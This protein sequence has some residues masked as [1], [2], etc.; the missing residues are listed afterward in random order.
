MITKCGSMR[1]VDIQE[2]CILG[3]DAMQSGEIYPNS[4]RIKFLP[5]PTLTIEATPLPETSVKSCQN[6]GATFQRQ[7]SSF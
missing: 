1:K 5:L 6:N 3:C 2:Q 7:Y 4:T